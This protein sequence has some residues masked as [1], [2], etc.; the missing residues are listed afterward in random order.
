MVYLV[1]CCIYSGF[2]RVSTH[3]YTRDLPDYGQHN[4]V[5]IP[6][7][8][9]D[10]LLTR[11][12]LWGYPGIYSG[13]TRVYTL[14][15]P[16]CILWGYPGIYPGDTRVYTLGVPG[17]ILWEYPGIYSKG[18]RVYTL[19]YPGIYSGD[20]LGVPGYQLWG[21]RADILG[22][23]WYIYIPVSYTHLTLPTTPYV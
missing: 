6:G 18:T 15:V 7:Y 13:G 1:G 21:S 11:Y 20:N 9:H 23:T 4:Q 19:G 8:I 3:A 22:I 16:G 5:L 10:T 14:G 17:Y 12:I 2:A